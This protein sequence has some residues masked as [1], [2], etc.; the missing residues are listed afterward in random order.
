M[1]KHKAYCDLT[2]EKP[3]S[4]LIVSSHPKSLESADFLEYIW[5]YL[6]TLYFRVC[7]ALHRRVQEIMEFL[8]RI[9]CMP[10]KTY[11]CLIQLI[12][13]SY[14]SSMNE[15][16]KPFRTPIWSKLVLLN[17]L[18]HTSVIFWKREWFRTRFPQHR[19]KTHLQT[20]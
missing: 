19:R 5:F 3:C 12:W 10:Y 4:L 11:I 1:I 20:N 16:D 9:Y 2:F 8:F 18:V 6:I 14:E 13:P 7:I 15:E 17:G